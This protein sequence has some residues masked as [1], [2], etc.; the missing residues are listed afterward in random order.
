MSFAISA[1]QSNSF[2]SSPVVGLRTLRYGAPPPANA[3]RSPPLHPPSSHTPPKLPIPTPPPKI[4]RSCSQ[5]A[6]ARRSC[7]RS[8]RRRLQ[9]LHARRGKASLQ[10]KDEEGAGLGTT[11]LHPE[12]CLLSVVL[13]STPP[14][15]HHIHHDENVDLY[16]LKLSD[17]HL[18]FLPVC[19]P[20]AISPSRASGLPS[21]RRVCM[22]D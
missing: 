8:V 7:N 1:A 11:R 16:L 9:G 21:E 18:P 10:E 20:P 12:T 4:A 6:D 14:H 19:L 2:P 17:P 15:S 5:W 13:S 3:P 22:A